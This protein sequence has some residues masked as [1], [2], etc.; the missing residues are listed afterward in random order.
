M[1]SFVD[2]EHELRL[3]QRWTTAYYQGRPVATVEKA[4][5]YDKMSPP[6][7]IYDTKGTLVGVGLANVTNRDIKKAI[8]TWLNAKEAS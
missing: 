4:R 3:D 8:A 2:I 6:L 7:A 5:V 1:I